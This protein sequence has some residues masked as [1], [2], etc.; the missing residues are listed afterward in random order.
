MR[1]GLVVTGG[2]DRSGRERVI[3]ALLWLIERLARQHDVHVFVLHHEARPST[4]ALL[5]AT[6]HDLGRVR[7]VPGVRR[8]L[9][10]RRLQRAVAAMGGVDVLHGYWGL[11]GA[12]AVRVARRLGVP[13]VIS[14][15]SGEWVALPD[16]QYGL[17]RRWWDR[18]AVASAMRDASAVTVGTEVVRSMATAHGVTARVIPMGVPRSVDAAGVDVMPERP[19]DGPPWRLIHVASIN[20]VKDHDTLLRA[21]AIVRREIPDIYLDIIGADTREGHAARVADALGLRG[22]VV[23]HGFLPNDALAPMWARAHLHVVSSRHEGAGV[24][25]LEAG[26]AGVPTVGTRVGHIADGAPHR[27]VAVPP[28]DAAALA[29]AIVRLLG[30]PVERTVIASTARSWALAHDADW[31]AAT[32]DALYRDLTTR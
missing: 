12:A 28:A 17:Q 27:A 10:T 7:A 32:F 18:R 22:Q 2:V 29:A 11:P 20:P 5:G 24:A 30:D 16:I 4:Y 1:V 31:T 26:M 6:V 25:I 15:S 19:P 13:S 23:F 21:F 3:P 9:Q 14:A 8:A